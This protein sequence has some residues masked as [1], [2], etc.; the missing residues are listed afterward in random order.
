MN[1]SFRLLVLKRKKL[2]RMIKIITS[3]HIIQ[4]FKVK[5]ALK[6]GN[7][8]VVGLNNINIEVRK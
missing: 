2:E 3:Y 6:D 1:I 8:K 7:G 4:E 5:E